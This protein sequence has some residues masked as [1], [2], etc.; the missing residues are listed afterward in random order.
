MMLM[1]PIKCLCSKLRRVK[2]G[3]ETEYST[4]TAKARGV[5]GQLITLALLAVQGLSG[6]WPRRWPSP[7]VLFHQGANR[8]EKRF[9]LQHFINE[10][11]RG[12]PDRKLIVKMR[13]FQGGLI[14]GDARLALTA[15][16]LSPLPGSKG[17]GS[18]R[19]CYWKEHAAWG[20]HWHC[21]T[22]YW[23]MITEWR[24]DAP[25]FPLSDFPVASPNKELEAH[26]QQIDRATSRAEIRQ[27]HK[28]KI[29]GLTF[30]R[31]VA[32]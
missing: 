22:T 17:R 31:A 21:D 13:H 16:R 5:P 7:K 2:V 4:G 24:P 27:T 26:S 6:C 18:G 14:G 20:R 29:S 8:L 25:S 12:G 10:W 9:L 11:V 19:G 1:S 23:V 32:T 30:T 15:L 3:L 28:G